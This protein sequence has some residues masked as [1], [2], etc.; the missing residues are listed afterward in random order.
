MAMFPSNSRVVE[1]PNLFV[2]VVICENVHILPGVPKLFKVMLTQLKPQL[3]TN[4]KK[5]RVLVY[6]KLL[7]GNTGFSSSSI[8]ELTIGAVLLASQNCDYSEEC[9]GFIPSG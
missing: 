1:L 5:K 2:P 9:S 8:F 6:T 3:Q 4:R 7:E